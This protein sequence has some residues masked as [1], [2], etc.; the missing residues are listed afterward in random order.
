MSLEMYTFGINNLGVVGLIIGIV[1]VV[2][3]MTRKRKNKG[4][5]NNAGN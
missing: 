5:E 1:I 4:R 3:A 2:I